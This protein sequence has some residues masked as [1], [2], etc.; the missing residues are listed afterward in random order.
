MDKKLAFQ[1]L[2]IAETKEEEPIRSSYL[3]LLKDT[4]PE[5]DPEG[6][7]RLREA[8]EEALRSAAERGAQAA[9]EEPQDEIGIWM[10]QVRNVYRDILLRR[11]AEN[12]KPLFEDPVC[13]GFDTFL[14]AREQLLGF[15]SGHALLPQAVWVLLDQTF[16]VLEDFDALKEQF[17]VNFLKHIEYHVNTEDFLDYSLFE[18]RENYGPETDEE[19]DEYIREYFRIKSMLEENETE[20]VWQML[21]DMKRHG[22]YHPYEEVERLRLYIRQKESEKGREQAENLLARYP[23]DGYVQVWAG[24]IFF[25]A[26]EEERGYALWQSVLEREPDYYMAKYFAVG[27]LRRQKQWYQARTYINEL[28]RVNGRDDDLLE[29]EEEINR[30]LL[31][32]IQA[33]YDKE[34]DFEDL[35][36]EEVPLLL[37][38]TIYN[39][40]RYEETL[41]LLNRDPE[42]LKKEKNNLHLRALTLYELERYQEAIP[43]FLEY[44]ECLAE[45][46]DENE[47]VERMTQAHEVLGFCYFGM[48]NRK[49][50]ERELR[51]AISMGKNAGRRLKDRYTLAEKFLSFEEY[52]RAV[53][54]CDEIL[55]EDEGY[56]P[57]YLVRQEASYHLKRAQQVVDDYYRAIDLYAGYDKPYLY[58][59]K[60]FY[61]YSQYQDAI[62]VIERA[63]ENQ[64]EFSPKLRFQEANIRRMLAENAD[65]RKKVMEI[66][67]ALLHE[68][69]E[70]NGEIK[71]A[72]STL[73]EYPKRVELLFE[74]A[75]VFWDDEK[76]MDAVVLVQEA[77]KLEP[78]N[79][80]YRLMLGNILR[81]M[82]NYGEALK[83][84]QKVEETYHHAEFYFGMGVCYEETGNWTEAI[85]SY[86]KVLEQDETYRDTNHRLYRGYLRR[87][88]RTWKKKDYE[89]ALFYINKQLEVTN[90]RAYRLWDRAY[91]YGEGMEIEK[92]LADYR[93]ALETIDQVNRYIILENMGFD[94]KKD[95]QFEKA[96]GYFKQ[97][98]EEMEKKDASSKGYH[99]MAVCMMKMDNYEQ[100]IAD[101]RA[102]LAVFPKDEEMWESLSDCYVETDRFE[103]ALAVT[104]EWCAQ[105]GKTVGYY[106]QVAFILLEMGKI[107]ESLQCYEDAK[108]E[109]IKNAVDKEELAK[110]YEKWGDRF[111]SIADFAA[112]V[113]LYQDAAALYRDN[114]DRFDA[115]C[116]L[117]RNCYMAGDRE[118][119]ARYARR[120]LENLQERGTTAEDYM[121]YTAYAPVRIGWV[122]WVE[123]A[124]GNR[125]KA[126]G[127]FQ[128]MEQIRPCSGCAHKQCHEAALWQGY[129]YYSEGEF[130]KAAAMLEEALRRNEDCPEAKFLLEKMRGSADGSTRDAAKKHG[131]VE[132]LFHKGKKESR[133]Q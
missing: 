33:A 2:R 60:I 110:L 83:E 96:Y 32:L 99:N 103:E 121:S 61:D 71:E 123:L 9:E 111:G 75:L 55:L 102:G 116:K 98:V 119:A 120:V 30:E 97:A 15:L 114:W 22:I 131:F 133:Q 24:K 49:E 13:V 52:E 90:N 64:V 46:E 62:G 67:D 27:Y 41:A 105:S 21:S 34:E 95:R 115:E 70:E 45:V 124:L 94:C 84:Y 86:K 1:I 72:E 100:A 107:K 106:N 125:E 7:K 74:K 88:E 73:R 42:L 108:R 29:Q 17:H 101:F 31:P 54:E 77:I 12:W 130:E 117:V 35:K 48:E 10:K 3:A 50:G 8:Y 82:S 16:H 89:A 36:K 47:R 26:G 113:T 81:D 5:D 14:E 6:F 80:Y 38:R 40:E 4:N 19:A 87:Y 92:A 63:K 91:L 109:F 127:Y 122:A 93:E 68:T 20:G 126:F 51:G 58:A 66:L 118:K 28:L 104:K 44:L 129:Y 112:S 65:E 11:E 39:M 69:E 18:T 53:E 78:A 79:P 43:V 37:G 59:A 85:A 57:A 56:Y 132:K 23:G 76:F 25:D 128:K